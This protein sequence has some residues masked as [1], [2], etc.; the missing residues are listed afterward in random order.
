MKKLPFVLVLIFVLSGC[1]TYK[2]QKGL[3]P[4]ERGFVVS[5]EGRTVPEYTV[6]KDNTV[7]E[8]LE[9]AK[10]RFNRRKATVEQYYEKM[11]LM[12]SRFQET[13]IEPPVMIVKLVGG[14]FHL[15]FVAISNYKYEHDPKYRE[16]IIKEEDAKFY[17]ERSRIKTLKDGLKAFVRKDIDSEQPRAQIARAEAIEQKPPEEEKVM[18]PEAKP[19]EETKYAA[20]VQEA[21]EEAEEESIEEE[22]EAEEEAQEIEPEEEVVREKPV[23]KVAKPA[24]LA[25]DPK[26]VAIAR[27]LKGF[28]PLKVQFYASQSRSPNGRIIAY[29]WDFGDGD[30]STKPNPF[31]TYYSTTFEPRKY[32]ATLT[33]TDSKG[34]SAATSIEIEV[35]NK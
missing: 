20:Q 5:K 19:A 23:A 6:G 33:V 30:K 2:F 32:I 13:V 7:P 8:D 35:L 21:L 22:A 4:Y 15:P 12:K 9:T 26:A 16:Q 27:P 17:A 25:G 28:S 14:I 11:G 18:I 1:A 31:N 29:E 3:S 24:V 10:E 34:A